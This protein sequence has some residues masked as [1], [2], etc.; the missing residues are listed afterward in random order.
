MS[1]ARPRI[2]L[3]HERFGTHL[4]SSKKSTHTNLEKRNFKAAGELLAKAWEEVVLDNFPVEDD[5]VEN[6][7]KDPVDLNGK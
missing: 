5:Y 3:P 1:K 6:T 2:W 7:A 4:D